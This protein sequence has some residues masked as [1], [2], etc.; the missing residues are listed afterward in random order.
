MEDEINHL[1]VGKSSGYDEMTPK[2]VKSISKH[3]IKPLTHIY[4]Q[5]FITGVVPNELKIALVTPI[6]KANDRER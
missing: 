4:N 5:S 3:I 2:I 6:Y 1:K